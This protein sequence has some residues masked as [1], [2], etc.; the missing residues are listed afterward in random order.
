MV[1]T[2]KIYMMV[3]IFPDIVEIVVLTPSSYTL[4][5]KLDLCAHASQTKNIHILSV[6]WQH[7]L[8]WR[9]PMMDPQSQEKLTYIGSCQHLQ[10]AESDPKEALRKKMVLSI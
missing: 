7:V 2:G 3:T 9:S 10:T 6:N 5:H 8:N 1:S 4:R